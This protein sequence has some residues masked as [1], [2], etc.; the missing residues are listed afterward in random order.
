MTPKIIDGV[1]MLKFLGEGHKDLD[2]IV[3]ASF[4]LSNFGKDIT[5]SRQDFMILKRW[6]QGKN[7]I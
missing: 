2:N 6:D 5:E 4:V 1:V 7:I 3:N